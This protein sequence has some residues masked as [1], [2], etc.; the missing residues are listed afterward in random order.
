M[1]RFTISIPKDLK[2]ELDKIPEIDWPELMKAGIIK[3]IEQLEKF[4]QLVNEGVI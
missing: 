1:K 3:K 4:E 2:E